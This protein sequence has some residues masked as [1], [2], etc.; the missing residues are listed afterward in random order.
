MNINHLKY[1]T[2]VYKSK[3]ITKAAQACH[4]SQPSVT[5]AIN[6]LESH[7]GFKLFDR[8]N[9]K[10]QVTKEGESFFQMTE[11]FLKNYENY[12]S[13]AA[14]FAVQ[15]KASIRIG[16]PSIMGTFF[17]RRIIPH[18]ERAYPEITLIVHEVPTI[19][20]FEMLKNSELDFLLGID[21]RSSGAG[22]HSKLLL[23]TQ[24]CFAVSSNNPLANEPVITEELL[25]NQRMVI[26]AKGSYHYDM[27]TKTFPE[28]R[29]NIIMHS[30]QIST[31]KYMVSR[32]LAATIIYR[33]VI[34]IS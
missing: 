19:S 5:A 22:C 34:R 30:S 7:F 25:K 31:I 24:L 14:D 10:L 20:G 4:I 1:F 8:V 18:F 23:K 32:D 15:Q 17:L 28:L 3:S 27:V 29:R 6:G 13:E 11:T 2:E 26:I 21:N 12:C 16:V 33:D 9:N